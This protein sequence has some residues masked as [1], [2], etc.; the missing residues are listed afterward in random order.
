MALRDDKGGFKYPGY[1]PLEVPNEPTSVAVSTGDAS[2][3][4]SFTAP[5][6]SGGGTITGY[7]VSTTTGA[8]VTGSASPLTLTGLTNGTTYNVRVW[9]LNSFGPSH[10]G[11]GSGSPAA[12]VGF[13][14]GL[15]TTLNGTYNGIDKINISTTGNATDWANLSVGGNQNSS[16]SSAT[17]GVWAG[18]TGRLNVIDYITF[19]TQ[20]NA[21]DFGNLNNNTAYG[22]GASNA[23]R[24][25]FLR[26]DE[27]M[28][29]TI[30]STG[31]SVVLGDIDSI[32]TSGSACASPT[33][34]IFAG[35]T[36][37]NQTSEYVTIASTGTATNFGSISGFYANGSNGNVS[38]GVRGLFAGGGPSGG[39]SNV[40][41]YVTIATT[42]SGAD[43][44]DLTASLA[45]LGSCG[46]STR[47]LFVA[48]AG[49]A[50]SNVISYV[51]IATTGNAAD[52]GDITIA[53]ATF[54]SGCSN[55]H[56]GL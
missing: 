35:G 23:T 7:Q 50:N 3:G 11:T 27:M 54:I 28:Y 4:V 18:G 29:I 38:S 33:R 55:S 52:F 13:V 42:G 30:A 19:S 25:I 36:G 34:M 5:V 44:G 9:A 14:G 41:K 2:L 15:D 24:G 45:N 20:A 46:S 53:E 16:C 51:T 31:N 43:F 26:A 49:S 22:T 10:F 48:G 37:G 12:A 47:G 40:I 17:R 1:N 21:T 32:R 39:H 56:G 8:S 6:I